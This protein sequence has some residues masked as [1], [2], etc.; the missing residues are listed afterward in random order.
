MFDTAAIAVKSS[1]WPPILSRMSRSA[2]TRSLAL[3]AARRRDMGRW[4]ARSA[5]DQDLGAGVQFRYVGLRLRFH[6][7]AAQDPALV[8]VGRDVG[9]AVG[10]CIGSDAQ[11][12]DEHR[13]VVVSHA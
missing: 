13:P 7:H 1:G 3:S 5:R 4:Y 12:A 9:M 10:E 6:Q 8:Q 2:C 11:R